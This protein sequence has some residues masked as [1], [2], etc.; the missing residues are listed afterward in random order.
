MDISSTKNNIIFT[1]IELSFPV[2]SIVV[3][4]F[5][6]ERYLAEALDSLLKQSFRD[7]EVI[8]IDDGSTDNSL[9]IA[10]GYAASDSRVQVHSFENGGASVA[11]NHGIKRCVGEFVYFFDSDDRLAPDA[12]EK[13]YS[14]F[15]RGK[16]DVVLFEALPFYEE[17]VEADAFV[18]RRPLIQHLPCSG[19][20][21]LR[22]S[23]ECGK[24]F[25]SP[26][27]YVVRRRV[28]TGQQFIEGIAHEDNIFFLQLMTKDNLFVS[29]LN[30]P[31]FHRRLRSN[32]I[33]TS[34]KSHW[35]LKG[36]Q[37][38]LAYLLRDG[39]EWRFSGAAKTLRLCLDMYFCDWVKT[40]RAIQGRENIGIFGFKVL[41]FALNVLLRSGLTK[42]RC[43]D[44]L[45]LLGA[46]PLALKKILRLG[47]G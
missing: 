3:P 1:E 28:L 20:D 39:R 19:V 47:G 38:T 10:Q 9:K 23:L 25:V 21:F 36:Y 37:L 2:F 41:P 35:H 17:G 22:L 7:F 42:S 13:I 43:R 16:C 18:Y 4:V 8:V 24:Y 5:N 27:C 6:T 31:F 26:C 45:V 34:H 12:I 44:L 29:V 15:C 32:S 33:M 14:E 40:A 30:E 46:K 11:R